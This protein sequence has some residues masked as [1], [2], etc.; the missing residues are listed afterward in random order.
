MAQPIETRT[1]VLVQQAG[2]AFEAGLVRGLRMAPDGAGIE[3]DRNVL[4]EDDS[5]GAGIGQE[6]DGT[7]VRNYDAVS[8]SVHVRKDLYVTDPSASSATLAF[9]ARRPSKGEDTPL[10]V[11]VNGHPFEVAVFP[12]SMPECF[13][14]PD[15][16]AWYY[17]PV[18]PRCL[19]QGKNEVVFSCNEE[20]TTWRLLI[21]EGR[22]FPLGSAVPDVSSPNRSAKSKDGGKTW[23]YDRLGVDDAMDGE[24]I[25]RLH[26]EQFCRDGELTSPVI[27]LVE[28]DE[29]RRAVARRADVRQL[30]ADLDGSAPA[31]TKLALQIRTGGTFAVGAGSWTDWQDAG[32]DFLK[33]RGRYAQWRVRFVTGDVS[34]SPVLR[35]VT[36]TPEVKLLPVPD[37]KNV[38]VMECRNERIVR[39][40]YTYE[41]E[42]FDQPDLQELR[43]RAALDDV[44]KGASTEWE[45]ILRLKDWAGRQL[46][47]RDLTGASGFHFPDWNA[48]D[49]LDGR[50]WFC[51]HHAVVFMQA[52]Q[53]FGIQCRHIQMNPWCFS[54]HEV[55]E[56]WSN[57]Y[58]KWVFIDAGYNFYVVDPQKG[59]PM[60][61]REVQAVLCRRLKDGVL[62]DLLAGEAGVPA[63]TETEGALPLTYVIGSSAMNNK[64]GTADFV[65][66]HNKHLFFMR[67]I[68][69][70]NFLSKKYPLPLNH[71]TSH[72]P[73]DGYVNWRDD[74]TPRLPH[75]SQYVYKPGDM[76]WTLNQAE[77]RLVYGDGPGE[78]NV[79][80]DTETPDFKEFRSRVD[81]GDWGRVDA[82]FCWRLHRGLN[83]LEVRPANRAGVDGITS[84]FVV[85]WP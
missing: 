70:N 38:S 4:I 6:R 5:P 54:G 71:G 27:D 57:D 50:G 80:V 48:L 36:L 40:S 76:Y 84:W 15:R 25:V 47:R 56:V 59:E 31:G 68:P 8:K 43:R 85:S 42:T 41:Y 79:H 22:F 35:S 60:S 83:R 45:R 53:A 30:A 49:V 3:L 28:G 2:P 29:A 17:L 51:L 64:Y 39:S 55:N 32:Q 10:L 63:A 20:T 13:R 62:L 75:Y 9:Y 46:A 19:K 16:L 14:R 23:T 52:C 69:R 61:L 12:E 11:F 24:Y 33:L 78:L 1:I 34:V 44:V 77:V 7:P 37:G 21:S 81:D 82:V 74:H 73:W 67:I 26:L 18:P 66:K 72:W 65:T 58:G